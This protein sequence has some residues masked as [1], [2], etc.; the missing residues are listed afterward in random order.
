MHIAVAKGA[1]AGKTFIEYVDYLA[2]NHYVPPSSRD[3]VDHIRKKGNE[4]NH[5]IVIMKSEDAEEL[6]LFIAMLLKFIY[7]FP[8]R[9]K[10]KAP[11]PSKP[12][13]A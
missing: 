3:W 9:M 12:S 11:K 2:D 13:A 10:S 8:A 5:E 4:A 7:E 6:L 1:K